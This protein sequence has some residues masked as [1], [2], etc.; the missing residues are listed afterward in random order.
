MM[1]ILREN[2]VNLGHVGDLVK[3]SEGYARNFL[4]PRKLV[5]AATKKN[6]EEIEHHKRL[7]AKKREAQK[8]A[9]TEVSKKLSQVTVTIARKVGEQDK[10]FG[11][12]SNGDIAELLNKQGHTV[13]KRMVVLDAP[14]KTLGNHT[15]TI[16]LE[17]EVTA[18]VKV[19]VVKEA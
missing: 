11:S 14:I 2:V 19:V 1:V 12:V 18:S 6:V 5:V 9:A 4:L 13:D 15:V 10:L 3:V 17:S 7:L 8:Q 16:R